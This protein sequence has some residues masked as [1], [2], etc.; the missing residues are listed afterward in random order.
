[1]SGVLVTALPYA[2]RICDT[3]SRVY[4]LVEDTDD[5]LVT[6]PPR[7]RVSECSTCACERT[8][9]VALERQTAV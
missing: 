4:V 5:G 3:V 2:C 8:H 7:V 1:M 9:V 6:S